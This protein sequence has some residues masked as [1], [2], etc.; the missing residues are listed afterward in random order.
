MSPLRACFLVTEGQISHP[1]LFL[2][3]AKRPEQHPAAPAIPVLSCPADWIGYLGRCYY[4]SEAKGSWDSSQ[5]SCS[6]LG[7]SLARIDNE[8]EMVRDASPGWHRSAG[9]ARDGWQRVFCAQL[10]WPLGQL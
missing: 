4:F 8:K 6:S 9:L 3:P 7:A 10:S 5:S 1:V 2:S